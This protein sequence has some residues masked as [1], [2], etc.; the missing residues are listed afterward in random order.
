MPFVARIS[1]VTEYDGEQKAIHRGRTRV[2]DDHELVRRF[3]Q[4]FEALPADAPGM[5]G[6]SSRGV[7]RLADGREYVD[8]KSLP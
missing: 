7:C 4:R 6:F 2:S 8:P 3:P 1:F 5:Q